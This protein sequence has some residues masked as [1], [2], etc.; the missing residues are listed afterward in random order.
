M[1]S[2]QDHILKLEKD[3]LKSE[4]RKS[5]QRINEIL[6]NDFIEFCSSGNVYNY[7]NGDIHQAVDD[8]NIL[9]WEVLDFKVKELSNDCVLAMYNLIKHNEIDKYK[10]NSLRS[11]VWKYYDGNWKMIFHQG[12]LSS[13]YEMENNLVGK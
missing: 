12:T 6:S 9:D 5:S 4:V 2:I 3:L 7:K 13:E 10:K 8:N 11:S 1:N